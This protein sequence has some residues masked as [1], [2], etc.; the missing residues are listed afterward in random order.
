V[1]PELDYDLWLV[2]HTTRDIADPAHARRLAGDLRALFEVDEL[3]VTWL[4]PGG[5]TARTA[6][7]SSLGDEEVEAIY[8]R[9]AISLSDPADRFSAGLDWNRVP[10]RE[11]ETFLRNTGYRQNRV[12]LYTDEPRD[13]ALRGRYLDFCRAQSLALE[14]NYLY[15]YQQRLDDAR[16]YT[17]AGIG[18]GLRDVYWV[19]VFGPPFVEL[20]G[21][22]HLLSA[23]ARTERL[24]AAHVLLEVDRRD[25]D[26][27]H[28]HI[29]KEFFAP[30][31]AQP[32][33][34]GT[35]G[36]LGAVR[37]LRRQRAAFHDEGAQAAR[38]PQFDFSRILVD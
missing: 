29:G 3:T 20:I 23:P 30:A 34:P 18:A 35:V 24:G 5:Q 36:L 7:W 11:H 6:A 26:A 28:A 25:K 17:A 14:V 9:G 13:P 22:E 38:T 1:R 16:F 31:P 21:V 19:N 37:M 33:Q 4:P 8:A 10:R 32:G 15:A 2:G 27:V 12:T